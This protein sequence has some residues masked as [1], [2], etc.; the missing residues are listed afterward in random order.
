VAA[1]PYPHIGWN[2]VPGVP[3]EVLKLQQKVAAAATAL[4]NT[5]RQ[6]SK[7]TGESSY[8][9]GD[10]AEKFRESL[11]G[12]LT[13]YIK[14][15]ATSLRTAATQLH[16]WDGHL[17]SN[18]QLAAK[19]D[20]EAAE[21][22]TAADKAR[23]SYDHAAQHPDLKLA[24]QTFPSQEEAD[25]ATARLRAAER[26][27]NEAN[28]ALAKANNEYES[29][30]RKITELESEHAGKAETIAKALDGATRKAPD[31]PGFWD[32]VGDVLAGTW[33]FLTTHAG[34]IGAIAGLLALLPTPLA[35]VFAGIAIAASALS[36]YG[37]LSDADFREDLLGQNGGMDMFSAWAAVGGDV[38]G[39]V[40][41][42]RLV[43]QAAEELGD[44]LR[45]ANEMGVSVSRWEKTAEF[46]REFGGLYKTAAREGSYGMWEA[47]GES[48]RGAGRLMGDLTANGLNVAA[49]L[50]SSMEDEGVLPEEGASHNA[51]EDTKAAVGAYGLAR[52]RGLL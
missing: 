52:M 5:H 24:D 11:D 16:N 33:E 29:L 44:G 47:A 21:K 23:N 50:V 36:M 7:L 15:A 9:E 40:P 43:G 38:L 1:N 45:I 12:D 39:M 28:T 20:A 14:D 32:K 31:E 30:N 51:A 42:A 25:A 2:P 13:K 26:N 34:T 48:A 4:E 10:A 27:L 6:L 49:N 19:Y 37:N 18:R 41:G 22:K 8:W 35:P 3:S 17:G 46:G